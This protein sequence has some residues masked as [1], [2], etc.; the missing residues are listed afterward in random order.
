[1]DTS[2]NSLSRCLQRLLTCGCRAERESQ[3]FAE[4]MQAVAERAKLDEHAVADR[5]KV[6]AAHE[7]EQNPGAE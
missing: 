2:K 4:L 7:A 3:Y 5:A 6:R 1:L